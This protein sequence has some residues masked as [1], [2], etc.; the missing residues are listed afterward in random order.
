MQ[1]NLGAFLQLLRTQ[2]WDLN[3]VSLAQ[4]DYTAL[5]GVQLHQH[6]E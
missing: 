2:G 3:K 1:E 5:W 4:S 6:D